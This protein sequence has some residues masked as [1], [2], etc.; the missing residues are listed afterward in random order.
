MVRLLEGTF[1]DHL[2]DLAQG[3]RISHRLSWPRSPT[4]RTGKKVKC[5]VLDAISRL[6]RDGYIVADNKDR[7]S[8]KEEA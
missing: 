7:L 4:H 5:S 8:I 3:S 6:G 1:L 2:S